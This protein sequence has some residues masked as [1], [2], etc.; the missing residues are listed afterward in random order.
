[1]VKKAGV[2]VLHTGILQ[3][4]SI[5]VFHCALNTEVGTQHNSGVSLDFFA[6]PQKSKRTLSFYFA[7]PRLLHII[8]PHRTGSN[9][10]LIDTYTNWLNCFPLIKFLKVADLSWGLLRHSV[11]LLAGAE[12]SSAD[13]GT[14]ILPRHSKVPYLKKLKE[15]VS[16]CIK[17]FP[18]DSG[19]VLFFGQ[20]WGSHWNGILSV[21]VL[22]CVY[23][24]LICMAPV[25]SYPPFPET[26]VR[27]WH[28]HHD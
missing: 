15:E 7:N 2:G 12:N 13:A 21:D 24:T 23:A 1:M 22:V 5:R 26:R 25:C 19:A 3:H 27:T 8:T 14:G 18:N 16:Q 9:I 6:D 17:R 10:L 4:V 11:Q 20:S 28:Q